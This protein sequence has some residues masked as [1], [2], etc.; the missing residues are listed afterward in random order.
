[1]KK[2]AWRSNILFLLGYFFYWY[3]LFLFDRT[4]FAIS[5]WSKLEDKSDVIQAYLYG[6]RLD[7]SLASYLMAVPFLLYVIQLL[8]IKKP[9]SPWWL[10]GYTLFPTVILAVVTLINIPLYSAWGEKISKRAIQLGMGSLGGVS[11]SVDLGMLSG[12]VI[13]MILFFT[14]AHYTYHGLVVKV[15]KYQPQNIGNTLVVF[16]MGTVLL[17]T[18]IRGGYGRATLNPSAVYFS[19]NT[20]A[21]HLAVNTYW[22]FF[23][24]MT[25]SAKKNPYQFMSDQ[26]ARELVTPLL[27]NHQDSIA[28]VLKTDRPNIVLILLEGMVAQVFTELGGEKDV[29]P[30]LGKLMQEGVNFTQA[31]AAADRSD[32]GI[33]AVMSGFPSQGPESI[34]QYIPKHENLPGTG[35]LYDSLGYSTSFYHGG[36]SQFYNIKSYMYAHGVKRVVDNG[37]FDLQTKR[38]SWGVYDHI[39]ADRLLEDLDQERKTFFSIFY[40]LVNHEPY[41]LDGGYHFG[42]KTKADMYRSTAYYT[43]TM[44]GNFVERAKKKE[45]YSNTLFVVVSDHG[46]MYPQEKYGLE[47]PSRYHIPLFIFGGALKPEWRGQKIDQIV[48]QLDV[49]STLWNFVSESPSP[50]TYSTN[51]F[52]KNR[53]HAAFYNSNS[54]FGI[55]TDGKA[56]TYDINGAKVVFTDGIHTPQEEDSLMNTAKGYYQQVFRDFQNY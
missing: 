1:M 26:E 19:D 7:A 28:Q 56:A 35:Q 41:N 13:T 31:Y 3:V 51:L 10:R 14:L 29:T 55:I 11:S 4:V 50:F 49:A 27:P 20:V 6:I 42:D 22:A 52:A 24:D 37:N 30:N 54:T 43:D 45:W 5:N 34:I 32:K 46:N 8:F 21:N 18:L 53:P 2:H 33:I 16:I 47:H 38:N 15:A 36:Q 23:K 9:I 17:F 40:T 39:V 12:G 48:S 25:K 44:V